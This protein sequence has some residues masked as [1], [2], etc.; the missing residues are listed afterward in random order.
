[1]SEKKR[2]EPIC[3]RL[4]ADV[5]EIVEHVAELER[6]PVSSLFETS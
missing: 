3:A 5:L 1:M 6:R 4:D 2:R